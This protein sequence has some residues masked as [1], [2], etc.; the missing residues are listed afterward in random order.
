[1]ADRELQWEDGEDASAPAIG[2][3]LAAA[4]RFLL[5]TIETTEETPVVLDLPWRTES[6][7]SSSSSVYVS[8][9]NDAA[10][11]AIRGCLPGVRV[12]G[13]DGSGYVV[14]RDTDGKL[15]FVPDAGFIG[16][17]QFTLTIVDP[18]GCER[19]LVATVNVKPPS[20]PPAEITF[21]NGSQQAT[22]V[23]GMTSAIVGALSLSGAQGVPLPDVLVFEGADNAPSTRFA[24]S[25][26]RLHLLQPL[27]TVLSGSIQLRLDAY[28]DAFVFASS[29][30]A[31][32]ILSSANASIGSFV[33]GE[34]LRL[35]YDVEADG[36]S[37]AMDEFQFF[38]A[39]DDVPFD[40][41]AAEFAEIASEPVC[42]APAVGDEAVAVDL[43]AT[44]DQGGDQGI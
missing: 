28:D 42:T 22:V 41:G 23:A 37:H 25:G 6:D 17:T 20:D 32:E 21:A 33:D 15:V 9:I 10:A 27:D 8:E 18:N 7:P 1:M 26:G 38:L 13:D 31:V 16:T 12:G 14:A 34:A 4:D 24:V 11:I 43:P 40:H 19:L 30:L 39:N 35:A 5:G 2:E 3:R 36:K 44:A 29:E